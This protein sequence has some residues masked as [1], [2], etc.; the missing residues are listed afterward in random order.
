MVIEHFYATK[1]ESLMQL[2]LNSDYYKVEWIYTGNLFLITHSLH[3]A[4]LTAEKNRLHPAK[5]KIMLNLAHIYE[6]NDSP[7][8]AIKWYKRCLNEPHFSPEHYQADILE[9]LS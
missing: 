5:E 7:E 6:K 4:L 2:F 8:D 3:E 9:A 1:R